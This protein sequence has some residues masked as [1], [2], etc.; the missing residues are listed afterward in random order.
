MKTATLLSLYAAASVIPGTLAWPGMTTTMQNLK[1]KIKSRQADVDNDGDS[2]ND[3]N[4]MIGDLVSPGPTTPVGQSVANIITGV[5]EGQSAVAYTT[6][7]PGKNTKACTADKCCIWTYIATELNKKFT[8]NS[9]RC[10]GFA[11]AAIRMGFHDAGAWNKNST[12]GGADGS[13][14]LAG[15]IN[16]AENNGLQTILNYTQTVYTKYQSYGIGMADL[17]QFMAT[18]AT[19]SCPLG[20]R[21]RTYVGRKD[22][23][24]PAPNG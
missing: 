13:L 11:R 21:V 6:T 17:I 22:S 15:E 7:I 8:G 23:S 24:L 5:E 1:T 12:N 2:V 4:E 9:G 16:R 19:V 14:I 18:T 3:S 20:P 10:N